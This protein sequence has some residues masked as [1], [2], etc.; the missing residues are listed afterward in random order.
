MISLQMISQKVDDGRNDIMIVDS[1]NI[2]QSTAPF[3]EKDRFVKRSISQTESS[4]VRLNFDSKKKAKLC[5]SPSQSVCNGYQLLKN[6]LN[7]SKSQHRLK[8]PPS[9]YLL[10]NMRNREE[11]FRKNP[12]LP[13]KDVMAILAN[14]W[15]ILSTEERKP[16]EDE[17]KMLQTQYFHSSSA[18]KF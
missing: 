9:A 18:T 10:F 17:S 7:T 1:T 11:T 8:R 15:K 5:D 14:E 6:N 12:G 16:F 4:E 2:E 13:L 3:A